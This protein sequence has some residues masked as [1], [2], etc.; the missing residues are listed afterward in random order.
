[1]TKDKRIVINI[2]G[3]GQWGPNLI[4]N[5]SNSV[6]CRVGMIC[7]L[8]EERLQNLA[9]RFPHIQLTTNTEKTITDSSAQAVA[10]I[11]PVSTQ[12][13]LSKGPSGW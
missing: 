12:Y 7:D 1:M 4:R 9:P 6:Q 13:S 2:L 5:F 8:D 3:A 11:T 10:I